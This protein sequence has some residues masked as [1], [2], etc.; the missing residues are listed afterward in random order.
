MIPTAIV[1]IL[2]WQVSYQWL[3]ALGDDKNW[4]TRIIPWIGIIAA[5]SLILYT[6]VLGASGD[7]FR[8]QRRIGV[9]IY[10]TFTYLSQ[11]LLTRR[12]GRINQISNA[13]PVKIYKMQVNLVISV[14]TI[15]IVSLLLNIFY[16]SYN[17]IEDA[18]EWILALLIHGYF[19]VMYFAFRKTSFRITYSAG[20]SVLSRN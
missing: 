18:F 19:L 3:L 13:I 11:L 16:S 7:L 1:M 17:E 15:G 5:L 9:I 14:L 8:L 6:T 10:F 20:T 4:Q 12:V 2:F